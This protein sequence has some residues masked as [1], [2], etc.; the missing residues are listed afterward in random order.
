MEMAVS[1]QFWIVDQ[2]ATV[3]KPSTVIGCVD[4]KYWFLCAEVGMGGKP[5]E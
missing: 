1:K 3:T 2:D 4:L 5:Y